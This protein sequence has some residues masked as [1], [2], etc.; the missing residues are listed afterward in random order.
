MVSPVLSMKILVGKFLN[1]GSPLAI[2][3]NIGELLV[4]LGDHLSSMVL[5]EASSF[6]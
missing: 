4:G 5:K 1:I 2:P 6:T 3:G